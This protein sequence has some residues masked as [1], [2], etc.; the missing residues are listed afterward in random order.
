MR[1]LPMRY[2]IK[3]KLSPNGKQKLADSINSG[4]LENEKY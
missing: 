3:R 2:Y 1:T 4:N